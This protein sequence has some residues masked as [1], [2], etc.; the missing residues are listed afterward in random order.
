MA[1]QTADKSSGI[2]HI[3][4]TLANPQKFVA[5]APA[6]EIGMFPTPIR[7]VTIKGGAGIASKNLIT[8]HGV[9]TAITADEYE[10]ICELAHFKAFVDSGHIRVERKEY[11]ID[12]MVGDMNPRDPGGPITPSDYEATRT[13]GSAALPVSIEKAGN[14]W[15]AQQ[16][17]R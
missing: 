7:E 15:V 3:F 4:S 17:S 2:V 5:Y 8:A 6:A 9:H 1:K 16:L 12:K 14:G 13:D 11:D 10:A